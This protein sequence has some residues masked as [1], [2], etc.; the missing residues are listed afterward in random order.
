MVSRLLSG[1]ALVTLGIPAIGWA[2]TYPA[3]P[4]RILVGFAAG[5]G[6]DITARFYALRLAEALGQSFIVD[7]RPGAAGAIA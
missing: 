7:N 4:V 6:I 2:Q 1:L 5:G 3:K